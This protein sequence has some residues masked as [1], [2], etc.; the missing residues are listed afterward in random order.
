MHLECR[1]LSLDGVD[2]GRVSTQAADWNAEGG[3]GG[4]GRGGWVDAE[5]KEG[6]GFVEGAQEG[7]KR[8]GRVCDGG[9]KEWN[10]EGR[11]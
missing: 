9:D 3:D 6:R 5:E 8:G 10:K 11:S 2:I 1:L 4:G 7:K